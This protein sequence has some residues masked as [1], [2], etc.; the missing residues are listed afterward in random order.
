MVNISMDFYK[1]LI[2]DLLN[3]YSKEDYFIFSISFPDKPFALF[4]GPIPVMVYD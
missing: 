2:I 3:V 4:S 1:P